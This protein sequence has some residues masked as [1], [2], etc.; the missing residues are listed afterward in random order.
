LE[1][2][3]FIEPDSTIT[4]SVVSAHTFVGRFSE[5][6][7]SIALGN[8]LINWSTGSVA[9]I[10]D[11]FVLCALRRPAPSRP[12]KWLARLAELYAGDKE[13]DHSLAKQL[14]MNKGGQG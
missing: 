7:G 2:G 11:P 6:V 1:D 8:N 14:L 10:P 3:A 5:I 12:A 9:I 13:E 4:E